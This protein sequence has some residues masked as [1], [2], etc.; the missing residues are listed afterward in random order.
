M[1]LVCR[2]P[3]VSCCP[4]Y[5]AVGKTSSISYAWHSE[6]M[7]RGSST[8]QAHAQTARH[9]IHR[10]GSRYEQFKRKHLQVHYLDTASSL[11]QAVRYMNET[12]P[13]TIALDFE[14][15]SK[16]GRFGSL[17]GSLRLIQIGLDE[18]ERDIQP[19]Q[20]IID[21]H[22][23]DPQPIVP[24]LRSATV[25][26]QIHFM[27]FEQEWALNHLG[28]SI[29][30]I[31]DTCI[32]W[33]TIQQQL[34]SLD[35][36]TARELVPGWERHPSNLATVVKKTLGIVIPKE[37]QAGDWGRRDLTVNQLVYA[38]MDVATLPPV[39]RK[40]KEIA[41]RVGVEDAIDAKIAETKNMLA[42]RAARQ[43]ADRNDDLGRV[44]RALQRAQTPEELDRLLDAARRMTITANNNRKLRRTYR[45][46]LQRLRD[47]PAMPET[48]AALPF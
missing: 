27:N 8:L 25:E 34:G 18:P 15:A 39:V 7:G 31:Y 2:S 47:E 45:D 17:N 29:G 48:S 14:T 32:A 33:K 5:L 19:H 21:C 1:T 13:T 40:T 46:S 16:N 36:A 9:Q 26:K 6:H 3:S 42:A 44:Q 11:R 23:V 12:A 24:L 30:N 10:R 4:V 37:E 38:A 41:A 35:L 28:V 22:H 20:L 43:Q